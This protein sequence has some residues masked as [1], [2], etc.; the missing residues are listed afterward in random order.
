[1]PR[2]EVQ[3]EAKVALMFEAPQ[4]LTCREALVHMVDIQFVFLNDTETA[5]SSSMTTLEEALVSNWSN[6]NVLHVFSMIL[7]DKKEVFCSI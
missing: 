7:S 3:V 1:M 5:P 4:L 6:D 2:L